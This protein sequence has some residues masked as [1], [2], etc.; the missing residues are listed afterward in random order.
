MGSEKKG[1]SSLFYLLTAAV[2]AVFG[3]S[4]AFMEGSLMEEESASFK[5]TGMAAGDGVQGS[6]QAIINDTC[7][8][9]CGTSNAYDAS[10]SC[11]CDILCVSAGDCCPDYN[12]ECGSATTTTVPLGTT[13]TTIPGTPDSCAGKCGG[14]TG[15]CWCDSACVNYGDCCPD[16]EEKCG[17]GGVTTTTIGVTTTTV[18]GITTTISS[19]LCSY[20]G[21]SCTDNYGTS[22]PDGTPTQCHKEGTCDCEGGGACCGWGDGSYCEPSCS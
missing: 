19:Q 3:M 12:Q 11:Q 4:L 21:Q 13:T 16:K 20:I 9:R 5:T 17:G 6:A 10:A 15:T 7:S 22:C 8:G 2:V 14:N 18:P 1:P